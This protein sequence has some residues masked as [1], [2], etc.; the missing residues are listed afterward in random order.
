[1]RRAA[2]SSARSTP[3]CRR[4]SR[5]RST[6]G[7]PTG[8]TSAGKVALSSTA[9]DLVTGISTLN[10]TGKSIAYELA[11]TSAAGVVP[12]A[13]TTVTLTIMAEDN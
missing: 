5:F 12:A 6:L 10:E 8:A 4:A 9:A 1:M 11:A 2:R 7:A 3:T 13:S